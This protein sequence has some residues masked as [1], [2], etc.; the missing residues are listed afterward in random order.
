MTDY[1]WS[2]C[3]YYSG[4]PSW[5]IARAGQYDALRYREGR[6]PEFNAAWNRTNYEEG[7]K[8]PHPAPQVEQPITRAQFFY[9]AGQAAAS[10]F[11]PARPFHSRETAY[12]KGWNAVPEEFRGTIEGVDGENTKAE[13]ETPKFETAASFIEEAA[14]LVGGSRAKTHGDKGLNF[15]TTAI[16]HGALDDAEDHAQRVLPPDVKFALRMVLAKMSRVISGDYNPDDFVDMAG[17]A[18]CAGEC[19]AAAHADKSD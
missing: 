5:F 14:R 17:Y 9:K 1:V 10:I 4:T 13:P 19:A 12:Y 3:G 16:L 7:T 15:R 6:R 11:A 8:D 2:D 18:G